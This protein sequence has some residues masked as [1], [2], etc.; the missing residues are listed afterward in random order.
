M[1]MNGKDYELL[2]NIKSL[3]DDTLLKTPDVMQ[4]ARNQAQK[5]IKETHENNAK[6]NNLLSRSACFKVGDT[7][8]AR[9]FA[10]SNAAKQFNSKLAPV[11]MKATVTKKLSHIYYELE[12]DVGKSLGVYH[13]KDIKS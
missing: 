3:H 7:V 10:Q 13:L 8:Y 5:K 4:L 2:R 6:V 1:I 9:S 12:N 11:F